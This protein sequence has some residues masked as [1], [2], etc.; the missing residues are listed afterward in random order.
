MVRLGRV[1][2]IE[3][4]SDQGERVLEAQVDVGGNDVVRITLADKGAPPLEGDYAVDA[5]GV[6]VATFDTDNESPAEPG[7]RWIAGR[8][9]QGAI[10]VEIHLKGDGEAE[11]KNENGFFRLEASGMFSAN[12]NFEVDP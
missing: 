9:A 8:D 5:N 3:R 6:A 10:V 2:G 1:I 11:V 12:G 7:E 4:I